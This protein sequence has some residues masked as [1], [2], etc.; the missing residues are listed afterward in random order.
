[1]CA[2]RVV[3]STLKALIS[4]IDTT[5]MIVTI[6]MHEKDRWRIANCNAGLI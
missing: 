1:M 6:K 5:L 2:T 4:L 3:F